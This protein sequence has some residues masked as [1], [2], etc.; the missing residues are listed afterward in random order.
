MLVIREEVK[1]R[2][3]GWPYVMLNLS[4]HTEWVAWCDGDIRMISHS[5]LTVWRGGL[6]SS[7]VSVASVACRILDGR[8]VLMLARWRRGQ[9]SPLRL[10]P[11]RGVGLRTG[12]R[13]RAAA[14][15]SFLWKI[16]P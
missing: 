7:R 10:E 2:D 16:E 3:P 12:S 5:G 8:R 1:G 9:G 13:E 14:R 15:W 6:N 4:L 11:L